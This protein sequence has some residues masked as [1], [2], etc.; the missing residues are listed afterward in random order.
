MT[1]S[2]AISGATQNLS[3]LIRQFGRS[4]VK[5][6]EAVASREGDLAEAIVQMKLDSHAVK[7]AAKA[8]KAEDE[9]M[10]DL[11]NILA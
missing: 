11:L 6:G 1:D 4:A 10:E 2:G 8:V 9:L 7:A 5:V 3:S